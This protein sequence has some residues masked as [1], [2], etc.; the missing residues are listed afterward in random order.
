MLHARKHRGSLA[1][2]VEVDDRNP[3]LGR[4][5]ILLVLLFTLGLDGDFNAKLFPRSIAELS[6]SLD[7]LDDESVEHV[8]GVQ[9]LGVNPY[10]Y[11]SIGFVS[12]NIYDD[13]T[14]P[15]EASDRPIYG[16]GSN[17]LKVEGLRNNYR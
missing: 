7:L 10:V 9:G 13:G 1:L 8:W 5:I 4:V 16:I 2:N 17:A 6:F 14:I 12:I 15:F 11:H 3:T